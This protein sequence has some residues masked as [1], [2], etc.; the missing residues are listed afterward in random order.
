MQRIAVFCV[1]SGYRRK[2]RTETHI[3]YPSIVGEGS[4]LLLILL[5]KKKGSP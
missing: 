4:I 5:E 2:E 3:Q 1:D